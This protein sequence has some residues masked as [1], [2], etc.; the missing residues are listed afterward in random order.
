MS[1]DAAADDD[2][3]DDAQDN[4]PLPVGLLSRQRKRMSETM[5]KEGAHMKISTT[6]Q[7]R[8]NNGHDNEQEQ[9]NNSNTTRRQQKGKQQK[10]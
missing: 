1:F 5:N 7:Q 2:E 8:G 3:P 10:R 9:G 6:R 4:D